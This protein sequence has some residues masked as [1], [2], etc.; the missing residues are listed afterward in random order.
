MKFRAPVAAAI[1]IAFG[2]VVL[3]GYFIPADMGASSLSNLLV[4][5]SWIIGWAVT[6]AGFATLVAIVGL[7]SAH[8]RK[9]RARRN[10]DRYSLFMLA[11][12]VLVFVFGVMQYLGG[13]VTTF[14]QIVNAIQVPVE[15]SMMAILAVTLT[16]AAIGLFRRRKGLLPVVFLISV[17]IY[18]LLNSGLLASISFDI[19]LPGGNEITMADILTVIQYLPV[20]GAR[21]ILIGIALGSLMAGLRILFDADRPYSG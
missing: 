15:A 21:G 10:P 18:L 3:L 20:A 17:L 4:L 1:A 2:L 14:Q 19:P 5:R 13:D 8:W 9:L 11:A 16:M 7:V 6:L 12:F